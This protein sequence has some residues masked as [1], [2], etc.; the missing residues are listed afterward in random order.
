RDVMPVILELIRDEK[1][2]HR[3]RGFQLLLD[4]GTAARAASP[5]LKKLL[6]ARAPKT[7]HLAATALLRIDPT[8]RLAGLAALGDLLPQGNGHPSLDAA[9]ALWEY[10]NHNPRALAVLLSSLRHLDWDMRAHAAMAF[11]RLGPAAR[12]H[13]PALLELLDDV[14]GDLIRINAAGSI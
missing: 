12:P 6:L 9:F 3:A 4:F 11:S 10:D 5:V 2:P 1:N 14:D 8:E 7:R 13:L